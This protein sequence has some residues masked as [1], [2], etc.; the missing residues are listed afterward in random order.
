[1][2]SCRHHAFAC[3]QA[4]CLLLAL[5]CVISHP[6]AAREGGN[7]NAPGLDVS[8][9][10][11]NVTSGMH[12]TRVAGTVEGA[13]IVAGASDVL[14]SAHGS[15]RYI[16]NLSG[17]KML[18]PFRTVGEMT[19]FFNGV[20]TSQFRFDFYRPQTT[21]TV[22][23][24]DGVSDVANLVLGQSTEQIVTLPAARVDTRSDN[25][26]SASRE[27]RRSQ[28][29]N[30]ERSDCRRPYNPSTGLEDMT[31][32]ANVCN[33][34]NWVETVTAIFTYNPTLRNSS[35]QS[36]DSP[37]RS[38][39]STSAR[40]LASS[41]T[42]QWSLSWDNSGNAP[43]VSYPDPRA[44]PP[45]Y[46]HGQLYW[47][48]ASTGNSRSATAAELS[49][50][51]T[52]GGMCPEGVESATRT[53]D[54]ER[55]YQ[56]Y[57]AQSF[58]QSTTRDVNVAYID[59]VCKEPAD[60]DGTCGTAY[61]F[62]FDRSTPPPAATNR[63]LCAT[64]VAT[65]PVRVNA[66]TWGWQCEGTE[67]SASCTA[68]RTGAYQSVYSDCRPPNHETNATMTAQQ[69]QQS[70]SYRQYV[71]NVDRNLP[72]NSYLTQYQAINSA[73]APKSYPSN[74]AALYSC[75]KGTNNQMRYVLG[76][77]TAGDDWHNANYRNWA[78][79][80]FHRNATDYH[81]FYLTGSA[82]ECEGCVVLQMV[83]CTDEP[84]YP[85]TCP[86]ATGLFWYNTPFQPPCEP[87]VEPT[88]HYDGSLPAGTQFERRALGDSVY[89]CGMY[90]R[91]TYAS[92]Q[93]NY[94]SNKLEQ[95]NQV[96][97]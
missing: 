36:I 72:T 17:N 67:T 20:S 57:D 30:M 32:P 37:S 83:Y 8:K 53:W 92:Q 6:A 63:T 61:E 51:G 12:V 44:C 88:Y 60:E 80:G 35:N 74:Q 70:G 47:D 59:V 76:G 9:V 50:L 45:S 26:F 52:N 3:A 15:D 96:C 91:W 22:D 90:G 19:S 78:P 79:P 38:V 54:V 41:L 81:Q 66:V 29:L 25:A 68:I 46:T 65:A 49:A 21:Q 71:C 69:W 16:D 14:L 23:Y 42:H 4:F 93:G 40:S 13:A 75:L 7:T 43:A 2:S 62:Y 55:R 64:G 94:A 82:N 87:E 89:M 18:V 24:Q 31:Q 48:V 56:C 1:M 28:D 11:D 5:V 58:P 73:A 27:V 86:A 84:D 39:L 34:H 10:Q 95:E 85:T 77:R 33:E 97:Q